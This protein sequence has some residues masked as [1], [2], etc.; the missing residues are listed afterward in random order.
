[1]A[2]VIIRSYK[3]VESVVVLVGQPVFKFIVLSVKP[4]GKSSTNF[5]NLGIR[6]LYGFHIPDLGFLVTNL[7]FFGN[8]WCG[9]YECV[10]KQSNPIKGSTL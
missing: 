9:V 5:V 8:V 2:S 7:D 4:I 1:M 6:H 10:F 3:T